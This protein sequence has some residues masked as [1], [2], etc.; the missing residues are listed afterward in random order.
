MT[1]KHIVVATDLLP[2]SA[3]AL[4]LAVGMAG[5]LRAR[6]TLAHAL[7]PLSTP[8]GL[9][10]FALEGMPLD[11]EE[12]VTK[13]RSE[14]A[15]RRLSELAASAS[16]PMVHVEPLLLFG[17]LPAVLAEQLAPLG[18]D[19]LVVGTHGRRGLSHL[20]LGSVAERLI[21][22]VHCPVL[23]VHPDEHSA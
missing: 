22:H 23:V 7:E 14:A 16:T 3:A 18:A 11:W 19:L 13:G 15:K 6:V 12:R 2:T 20:L 4:T 17:R 10:A 8:P 21:R 9:E 1:P 5:P